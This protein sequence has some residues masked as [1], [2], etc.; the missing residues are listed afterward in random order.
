MNAANS[1]V[2]AEMLEAE[3]NSTAIVLGSDLRKRDWSS[4]AVPCENWT[5]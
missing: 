5:E 2:G 4:R 1:D 3:V